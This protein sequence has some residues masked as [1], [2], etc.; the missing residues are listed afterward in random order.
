MPIN[1]YEDE[2]VASYWNNKYESE[3][4]PYLHGRRD[5]VLEI[6]KK[7]NLDLGSSCLELGTGGGQNAVKYAEMG[8]SVHGIDSSSALLENAERLKSSSLDLEFSCVDLNT[9]LPFKDNQFDVVIVIGT[10]QYLM[11]PSN[12]IREVYRVLKPG[13][14][15][16]ICQRNGISFNVMRRPISFLC[17]ALSSE[18]F[19]W[20]GRNVAT[21]VGTSERGKRSVLIKRMV[22]FSNL[23]RWLE[24]N[25][26]QIIEEKG[27][28]P[29]FNIAPKFFSLLDK[30]LKILPYGYK[31][32]HIILVTAKKK[33]DL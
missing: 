27:Y 33:E 8:F 7:L 25:R 32:A 2:S 11:E 14:Y 28:I 30:I 18:G 10:L 24:H 9:L 20:A 26:F 23:R 4:H 22:K 17:C 12:C 21:A 6:L 5:R 15:F 3:Y 1:R 29:D 16:I 13:G 31:V 19:E